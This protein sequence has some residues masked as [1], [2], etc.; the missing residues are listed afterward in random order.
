[1]KEFCT[2]PMNQRNYW[3][4]RDHWYKHGQIRPEFNYHICARSFDGTLLNCE[5]NQN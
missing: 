3:L 1:M 2:L 5:I 4:I